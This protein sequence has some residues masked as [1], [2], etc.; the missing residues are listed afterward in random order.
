MKI[1]LIRSPRY[2]WPFI[3]EYDNFLLPQSLPCLAGQLR[4]QGIHVIPIDCMPL[5]MGWKTL[6][7]IIKKEKPDIVGVGDSESLYSKEA[8]RTI[9]LAKNIDP[10]IITI[11]GGAHFSNLAEETLPLYPLDIIVRGE[12]EITLTELAKELAKSK[13]NLRNIQGIVFKEGSAIIETAPRPLISNLDDL[14]MPAYDLMP[15]DK[16]GKAKFLFSPGGTT[17]HHSR[18]CANNCDFCVWWVQM[19]ERKTE[20][21]KTKL[22]PRWRTKSVGRTIEEIEILYRTYKKNS[23]IFVDDAWNTDPAWNEE[24]AK[25]MLKKR[26]PVH[27]F[28]FMRADFIIRDEKLGIMEKL[29]HAGLSHVSI[30]AERADG[31]DL[32]KLGKPSYRNE[33]VKQAM[34]ILRKKYPKVFRQVTFIVG[35]RDETKQSMLRQLKYAQDLKADYPAFHPMTPIPGTKLWD[36]AKEKGWLEITDFSFYDWA[37]P[38]M[39]SHELSRDEIETMIYIMNKKYAGFLWLIQG[40]FS[41]FT[42]KRNMYIWW[43]LVVFRMLW[44]GILHLVNPFKSYTNLV[45]PKW[46]DS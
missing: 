43:L 14:P 21:G 46:Y 12:G 17:I 32:D 7:E 4:A 44:D 40:L 13:P 8:I 38:V 45:K 27:W 28:A 37:T 3:N 31:K 33:A 5:K 41:P 6:G 35:T 30:G 15:M 2:Y 1:L 23:L 18:G 42:Y 9:E 34:L 11:A 29:V 24:F 10:R 20:N 36:E 22:L 19:A 25:T 16:Y 39:S 26:L